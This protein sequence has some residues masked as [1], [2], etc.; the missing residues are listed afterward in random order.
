M[1]YFFTTFIT[2]LMFSHAVLALPNITSITPN[3]TTIGQYN[4]LELTVAISNTSYSNPYD[5]TIS[6]GGALL[7]ATF[8]SP[9]GVI[10]NVDGFYL[11]EYIVANNSTGFS[12]TGAASWRIRFTPNE[13]GNW[14]YS[15]TF[16]DAGG[17]ST[18]STGAF[19]CTNSTQK[20]FV[21]RQTGKNYFKFDNNTQFIPVG[22]NACWSVQSN[23]IGE[24][25]KWL[26][27]MSAN[28]SNYFRFWFCYWGT[29]LEW[30]NY[31]NTG[32][33]GLKNYSQ[34]HAFE[35]DW[36]MDY[37]AQ[38]GMYIDMCLQFHGQLLWSGND[39]KWGGNP[40]NTAWSGGMCNSPMEFWT[41]ASAKATYKNKLRY[42]IARWGYSPNVAC[43]ELF[44]EMNLTQDYSTLA[45][46]NNASAWAIEM[47]QYLKATDPN[48]HLVSNSY[49]NTI[50]G[51]SVWTDP[52]FDWVQTH[53]YN[54]TANIDDDVVKVADEMISNY[55][56]PYQV[57]EFGIYVN[58]PSNITASNDPKAVHFHNTMWASLFSG[59]AGCGATWWW[60]NFT[61]PLS[62]YTY[63]VFKQ[64]SDFANNHL[65]TV[66]KNYATYKPTFIG[67]AGTYGDVTISAGFNGFS[68]V[69]PVPAPQNNFTIAA[70]GTISP[71]ASNLSTYLF[72]SYHPSGRNPP[73][74]NVNYPTTGTFSVTVVGR[75]TQGTSNLLIIL[76]GTTVLN[77]SY[78]NNQAYSIN[79]PAG[80]HTIKVDDG[81]QEWINVSQFKFTN[82]VAGAANIYCNS[83]KDGNHIVGWFRNP[84]YTWMHL[85][86]V[87]T[88]PSV[89]GASIR[90]NNLTANTNYQ[91]KLFNTASNVEIA[92]TIVA[93]NNLGSVTFTLPTFNWDMAFRLETSSV[94]PVEIVYFYGKELDNQQVVLNWLTASELNIANYEVERSNDAARFKSIGTVNSKGNNTAKQL[95]EFND[96]TAQLGI[97]YYRLK[98]HERD[99]SYYYSKTIA[100]NLKNAST[101]F[102]VAVFPNPTIND[103]Q[104]RL[105]LKENSTI[106]YTLTDAIGRVILSKSNELLQKGEQ[107]MWLPMR[108]MS[109]GIYFLNVKVDESAFVEKIVK[110]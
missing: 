19:N 31:Y 28:K 58:D 102:N 104:V 82:Y 77:Q 53:L 87:G 73:T 59:A 108:D 90:F 49:H 27:Q 62:T 54:T 15:L 107:N 6:S 11:Q 81:G 38:N 41:N 79:V 83:L 4:K 67:T 101:L 9:S 96:I 78:P 50:E 16:Q 97:N 75:G 10:K 37:A 46:K 1:R 103:V 91:L 68:S 24:Y 21:R 64:V 76:D 106:N 74:F 29:E 85:R 47:G 33:N 3:S 69:P 93:A 18:T 100:I 86:D 63:P 32:Y 109:N 61:E 94:F 56:K 72:N 20:G 8:T 30:T 52:N 80:T 55:N 44:N 84:N 48:N 51:A 70:D 99:G 89:S 7:R 17:I 23:K 92:N 88:P 13:T 42:I 57:G 39:A 98:I 110:E 35:V 95:Y 22:Q 36:L 5:Y 60:D 2:I 66:A 43:W 40:Y 26:D 45:N 71:A 12:N 34:D 25:K 14:T 65:N 105:N